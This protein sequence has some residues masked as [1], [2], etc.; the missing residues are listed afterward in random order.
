MRVRARAYV[1]LCYLFI[2]LFVKVPVWAVLLGAL[3]AYLLLG[4]RGLLPFLGV[5]LV[6]FY[7][8]HNA[9]AFSWV[10]KNTLMSSKAFRAIFFCSHTTTV[11][12]SFLLVYL[13]ML[14]H[15]PPLL[16]QPQMKSCQH[17]SGSKRKESY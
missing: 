8:S 12:L 4:F 15:R 17:T 16:V 11:L 7:L 10:V 1:C 14:S 3:T 9:N 6:C 13:F 5:V 2:C